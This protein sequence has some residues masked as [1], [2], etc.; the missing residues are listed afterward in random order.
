MP[1]IRMLVFCSL[2]LTAT[3]LFAQ[4]PTK[5]RGADLSGTWFGDFVLTN[6]DGKASH[7]TAVLILEQHGSGATGSIGPTAD[8]QAPFTDGHVDDVNI[9][10]HLDA[11]GGMDFNLRLDAGHLQGAAMG[12]TTKAEVNLQ[13]APGLLPHQKLVEEI[14]E[15]DQH[16]FDAFGACDATRYASF[17]S[18]DLEFYQDHTGKKGYEQNLKALRDRCAEGIKL[19]RELVEGSLVVNAV[20][21]YGAIEA[22][23]HRFYS[24]RRDGSEHLDATAQFTNVWSKETGSW[25]LVRVISYDHR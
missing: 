18:K 25:K 8:Q 3:H 24:R 4:A 10:F 5:Q 16:L 11:R 14:T 22:G 12:K 23:T 7:D 1:T 20:P 9:R 6:P 21:G 17:L 15:A 13:P 19:R 2:A